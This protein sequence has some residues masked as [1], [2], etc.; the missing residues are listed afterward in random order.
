MRYNH[1]I[2]NNWIEL[3][4]LIFFSNLFVKEGEREKTFYFSLRDISFYT[5]VSSSHKVKDDI[6]P[7]GTYRNDMKNP[8]KKRCHR[9]TRR[10][11]GMHAWEMRNTRACKFIRSHR[12]LSHRLIFV[13]I[14]YTAC[15]FFPFIHIGQRNLKMSSRYKINELYFADKTLY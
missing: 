3:I 7:F 13:D 2:Y 8:C 1:W 5:W 15:M 9:T 10:L 14:N 6:E 12:K 4:T 11:F